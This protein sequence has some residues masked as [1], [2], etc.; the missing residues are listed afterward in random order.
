MI[1]FAVA[2]G[3]QSLYECLTTGSSQNQQLLHLLRDCLHGPTLNL[4]P[5]DLPP[6]FFI[7]IIH[8]LFKLNL[9]AKGKIAMNFTTLKR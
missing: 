5:T 6:Y 8:G 3:K 1:R 7:I 9:V 4:T 2:Q